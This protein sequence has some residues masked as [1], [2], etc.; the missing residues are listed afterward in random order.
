MV[1]IYINVETS[2]DNTITTPAKSVFCYVLRFKVGHSYVL[3]DTVRFLKSTVSWDICIE[4]ACFGGSFEVFACFDKNFPGY[5][6]CRTGLSKFL[7]LRAIATRPIH[8]T[9][10]PLKIYL[11]RQVVRPR[12]IG[13]TYLKQ[14]IVSVIFEI[15]TNY[16]F[17]KEN[18]RYE[19]QGRFDIFMASLSS[20]NV[21]KASKRCLLFIGLIFLLNVI[22]NGYFKIRYSQLFNLS[23][24]Y[25]SIK[26]IKVSGKTLSRVMFYLLSYVSGP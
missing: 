9:T 1:Y 26:P 24:I 8:M 18:K 3:L 19:K 2:S 17:Q 15:Y 14:V 5:K 11:A 13:R 16:Q 22:R 12:N 25:L 23:F 7:R 6:I 21:M 20:S 10:A 4:Q